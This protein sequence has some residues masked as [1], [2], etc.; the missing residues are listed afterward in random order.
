MAHKSGRQFFGIDVR[1]IRT[2]LQD[3]TE[4]GYNL[5]G[6]VNLYFG[7]EFHELGLCARKDFPFGH[8]RNCD[9]NMPPTTVSPDESSSN[10]LP[11]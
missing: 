8:G 2:S 10:D 4:D 3:D 1:G 9:E 5:E 7:K 6:R 11:Y